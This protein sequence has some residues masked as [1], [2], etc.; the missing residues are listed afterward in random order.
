MNKSIYDNIIIGGLATAVPTQWT[1]LECLSEFDEKSL[2]RFKKNIG[3]EGRYDAIDQQTASDLA[4]IAAKRLIEHKG[5]NVDEIGILVFVTQRPDY[6]GPATACV[7]HKRLG[8]S[9]N[10]I[11]FDVNQGCTGMIHGISIVASMLEFNQTKNALLLFGDTIGKSCRR[12]VKDGIMDNSNNDAKLFGDA[13][14]ALL[15]Q[16][17]ES[18]RPLITSICTDGKGYKAIIEPYGQERHFYETRT[19][20]MDGGAVFDFATEK[21]PLLLREFMNDIGTS[22]SDYDCLVL[23]QANM[24]IIKQIAKAAG[25]LPEQNLISIDEFGNTSSASIATAL[26]KYYGED[27]SEGTIKA[28]LCGFGIGLSWG[29]ATIELAKKDIL[30][31]IKTDDYY[32]DGCEG[33]D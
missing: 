3:V 6:Y 7:L 22:P 16:K 2:K 25:F 33:I 13:A 24:L 11:A 29:C 9:E 14:S 28:M 27:D 30:P 19:F 21:P 32:D 18:A 17:D 4:Y 1:S 5:I 8:L 20:E 31:L 26:T 23:H 15:L 12:M 10:C